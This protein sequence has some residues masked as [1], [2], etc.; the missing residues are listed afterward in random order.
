MTFAPTWQGVTIRILSG[1]LRFY[2]R[3]TQSAFWPAAHLRRTSVLP[4]AKPWRRG[5]SLAPSIFN[6]RRV[7]PPFGR[8]NPKKKD[9]C[10]QQ[11]SF[12]FGAADGSRTHLCSLGS[13]RSTDELQLRLEDIIADVLRKCNTKIVEFQTSFVYRSPRTSRSFR[14]AVHRAGSTESR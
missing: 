13:C 4:Q 12:F 9:I 7:E 6:H 2:L 3:S 14:S 10:F 1:C 8:R 11:M 5:N